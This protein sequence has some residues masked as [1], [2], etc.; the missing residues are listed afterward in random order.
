MCEINIIPMP[1]SVVCGE[2]SVAVAPVISYD[3]DF[4]V[5]A[6]TFKTTAKKLFDL[7]V[8]DGENGIVL[9]NN[10]ELVNE[11]Y[12]ISALNGAVIIEAA[13]AD[14]INNGIATLYQLIS[15]DG[16]IITVPSCQIND[17]PDSPYRAL[18]IHIPSHIR[19]LGE[20]LHYIDLCYLYKIKFIHLH[21]ADN[22]AY[23]FPSKRFPRLENHG[24]NF[25]W[26]EIDIIKKYCAERNVEIIPEIDVPG[27]AKYLNM[28]YPELFS[29]TPI[30][31]D[32][33]P[34]I[35]CIGKNGVFDNIKAL[36]AEVME[37]FPES[38]Y[39]HIGGDEAQISALDNCVDCRRY[40]KEH[41]I[42]N[43]KELYTHSIKILTDMV[44]DMGKIP[45]VWE[46]FPRDG[47]EQISRDVIVTAWESLYHLPNELL[48]EGFTVTNSS[49]MPLYIVDPKGYHGQF[50]K[51]GRWQPEDILSDWDIYTWKNWWDK[52]AAYEKPIVVEPT[53]KVIGATLCSWS[54]GYDIDYP[55]IKENLPAMSEKI[56]NV[57]STY[58]V[59]EFMP[60][61]KKLIAL[62]DALA[63]NS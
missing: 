31:G 11:E 43:V 45:V 59:E 16:G 39:F 48:E 24:H 40:M 1:K 25:T 4:A 20:V 37:M 46:G 12:R 44:I 19:S 49:W 23:C 42:A 53:D 47:A 3:A 34:T 9:R 61:L 58:T 51:G 60:A 17:K 21:G 52:S 18:M 14:G 6:N 2:G 7:T 36:F 8:S 27:H 26:D 62:A 33:V 32:P 22:V 5:Y 15:V 13:G 63:P 55:P 38:R 29:D 28:T 50:V 41:G 57:N 54:W 30:E 35:V 56:W 10:P